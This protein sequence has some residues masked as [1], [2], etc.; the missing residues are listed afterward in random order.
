MSNNSDCTFI[1]LYHVGH[2]IENFDIYEYIEVM[3]SLSFLLVNQPLIYSKFDI[4][5]FDSG[6]FDYNGMQSLF[7]RTDQLKDF[8]Q[9]MD[10]YKP[11]TIRKP[12]LN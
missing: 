1:E 12:S 10:Q 8:L 11:P 2:K 3:V 5:N 4:K 6:T 7:I 9:F